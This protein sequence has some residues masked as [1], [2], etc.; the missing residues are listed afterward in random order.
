[1][2]VSFAA[3]FRTPLH[4]LLPSQQVTLISKFDDTESRGHKMQRFK[5]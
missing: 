4:P 5:E 2:K 1:M 3:F